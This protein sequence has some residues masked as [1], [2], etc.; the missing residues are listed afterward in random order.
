MCLDQL[1]SDLKPWL[2]KIHCGDCI[3]LMNQM[4]PQSVGGI[5]TSPPYNLRRGTGRGM[6]HGSGSLWPTAQLRNGYGEQH[7]D[8]MPYSEYIAWQRRCL[9]AML[10]V[11][12]PDGAIFYNHKWRVQNGLLQDRQEILEGFPVRQIIIWQRS[13]GINFNLDYFLPTYEVVYLICN[14]GFR[15]AKSKDPKRPKATCGVGDVW[16]FRQDK[17]NPHP[18]PF[19]LELPKRCIEAMDAEVILD[20]FVGSGTTALA[21]YLLG[22]HWIGIDNVPHYCEMARQRIADASR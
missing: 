6:K 16:R 19:P 1:S 4:P 13:G 5:V 7:K 10:R 12:K 15:L 14:R 2:N 9:T 22:R 11:L 8:D 17:N 21:A 3:T 20:P 18:A